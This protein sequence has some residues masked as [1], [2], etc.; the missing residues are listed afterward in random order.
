MKLNVYNLTFLAALVALGGCGLVPHF[1][2]FGSGGGPDVMPSGPKIFDLVSNL[3]CELQDA[4]AS[5]DRISFYG[6]N[7]PADKLDESNSFTLK[8]RFEDI[9]YIATAAYT[10]QVT[11]TQGI[12]AHRLAPLFLSSLPFLRPHPE[13]V[14]G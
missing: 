6:S 11:N 5:E 7:I 8:Q 2:L 3:Q 12:G 10:L 14:E 1:E 4:K 9:E 13:L